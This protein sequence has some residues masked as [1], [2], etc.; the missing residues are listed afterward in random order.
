MSKTLGTERIDCGGEGCEL[1]WSLNTRLHIA[2]YYVPSNGI[3]GQ[4][5]VPAHTVPVETADDGTFAD[6]FECPGCGYCE[7]EGE[8][9]GVDFDKTPVMR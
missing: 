9:Q 2:T 6:V 3:R 1:E 4:R 7:T 8:G 5:H